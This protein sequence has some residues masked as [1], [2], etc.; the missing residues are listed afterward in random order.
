MDPIIIVGTGLAGY[1]LAREFR[2]RDRNTP[3]HIITAD[4]GISYSKPMLSNALDKK[5]TPDDLAMADATKM[6][7]DLNAEIR[8][9]TRVSAVV[10]AEHI[11][12]TDRGELR[13]QKL[14]LAVG[15]DP[16]RIPL[17]GDAADEVLSVNDLEDYRRFR[18]AMQRAKRVAIIGAG[19]IGC[20]F[21]NDLRRTGVTVD[22][23]DPTH[24]PLG[25]LL[26]ERAGH[27]LQEALA[28]I[29]V[30]WHF[31][32]AVARVDKE[33]SGYRLGLSN[34][35]AL[36]ADLVLSAVGL[37]PRTAL[38]ETQGVRV[39]RGILVDRY[40]QASA[41]DVYALGDCAEIEGLVL[42]F[43]MPLM[44]AAR[45]LAATLAGEPTK[46]VYPAMPVY[47][48]TPDYP[49]VVC[50]PLPGIRGRWQEEI[51]GNGV[52]GLYFDDQDAL[53]GFALTGET[54]GEK[55]ALVKDIP[56]WLS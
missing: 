36:E 2:K 53:R 12:A 9:H 49:V 14:V 32:T 47:V 55:N 56:A 22:V 4:D 25:R 30:N 45:A 39:E 1:T 28:A 41:E 16:I 7:K 34:G 46:V 5:K 11:V 37:R 54:V 33:D 6:A 43:V 50:P 24:W 18:T 15:A 40:L 31:G 17:D 51:V 3:V 19:L 21:A 20:E 29:G 10:P 48:K 26:G 42:P 8:T 35:E 13:Y 38:A 44:N 52:R 23:I 27:A